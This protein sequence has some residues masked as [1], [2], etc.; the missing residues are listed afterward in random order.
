MYYTLR[1]KY[2][3]DRKLVKTAAVKVKIYENPT[4]RQRLNIPQFVL[5]Q[6]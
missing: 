3:N 5:K 2:F 6:F 4:L 1:V